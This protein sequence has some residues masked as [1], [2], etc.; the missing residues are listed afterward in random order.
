MVF[1]AGVEGP[2]TCTWLMCVWVCVCRLCIV[3]TY[4]N[5][6]VDVMVTHFITVAIKRRETTPNF[7]GNVRT[8]ESERAQ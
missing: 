5:V 2:H 6:V 1:S 7:G 4:Y 8:I 3:T